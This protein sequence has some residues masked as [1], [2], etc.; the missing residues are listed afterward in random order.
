MS[1]TVTDKVVRCT[2]SVFFAAAGASAALAV[3]GEEGMMEGL[4]QTE[5]LSWVVLHHLLQQV[6]QLV[7]VFALRLH[8]MLMAQYGQLL[9]RSHFTYG[10]MYF[11][12]VWSLILVYY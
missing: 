11:L 3:A 6:K 7:V 1:I 5:A 8:V 9:N 2:G 12:V 10:P 4:L